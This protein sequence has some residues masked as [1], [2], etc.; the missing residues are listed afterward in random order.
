ML[1]SNV[2]GFRRARFGNIEVSTTPYGASQVSFKFN[3]ITYIFTSFDHGGIVKAFDLARCLEY[4]LVN[5]Q[6]PYVSGTIAIGEY[7]G[8]MFIVR[9][10]R[11][12]NRP[13]RFGN[14]GGVAMME[15]R[16]H[17]KLKESENAS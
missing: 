1:V 7:T 9:E 4:A 17:F 13:L 8:N 5:K 16:A 3:E 10:F 12:Y 11:A 15:M 2:N 14:G 6:K